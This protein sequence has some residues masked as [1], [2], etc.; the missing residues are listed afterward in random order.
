NF[1]G[2][3]LSTRRLAQG[4]V[5]LGLLHHRGV[6]M[7]NTCIGSVDSLKVVVLIENSPAYDTYLEGCFGLSLWLELWSGGTC[8]RILF[9]VGPRADSLIRN[10]EML[11]IDLNSVDI[12]MLSHG[13]F[14]H[15]AALAGLF[16]KLGRPVPVLGH[17]DIFRP[18]F[19]LKPEFMDYSMSG[20]N[21]RPSLEARG[22]CMVLTK[23]PVEPFP[24]VMLT[25]EVE[26]TTDFEESGGVSC[27]TVDEQGNTVPDRLQDDLSV[28]VNVRGVG[29]IILSGCGH[30]GIVNIVKQSVRIS[31]GQN[32]A[33]II[34]GFH[35]LQAPIERTDQT[36]QAFKELAPAL[37]CVAPMHCTGLRPSARMAEVYGEAFRE[38]H[39]GDI[40]TFSA[41][42]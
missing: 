17:T 4:F 21:S 37:S 22:A 13:H 5:F 23:S 24:G 10:A 41:N 3:F 39:A 9:D 27:L 34:G 30:A 12:I 8:K 1:A 16:D 11:G 6:Q 14:D 15:T 18:N 2:V 31:G 7:G 19:V 42:A 38:L 40:V 20:L 35:L 33:G 29:L 28:L 32:V 26:H 36:I 25:G